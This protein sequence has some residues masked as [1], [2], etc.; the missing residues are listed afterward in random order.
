MSSPD[1]L[2][3][4]KKD[5]G[6]I[7]A[8]RKS[9]LLKLVTEKKRAIKE[10]IDES[11][12]R[13]RRAEKREAYRAT[14]AAIGWTVRPKIQHVPLPG[15]DREDMQRRLKSERNASDYE[16]RLAR[17]GKERKNVSRAAMSPQQVK[18][19]EAKLKRERRAAKKAEEK[20]L[21]AETMTA[22]PI[23]GLF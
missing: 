14:R 4:E 21:A 7:S 18:A 22:N 16:K 11:F 2:Q 3:Q 9:Q 19:H 17:S 13:T 10:E 23:F 20:R 5:A 12:R 8:S 6:R 1:D 15:E